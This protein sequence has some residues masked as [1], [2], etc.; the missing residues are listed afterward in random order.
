MQSS[1]VEDALKILTP[2]Q[3]KLSSVEAQRVMAVTDE[4]LSKLEKALSL[5]YLSQSMDRYSVSLGAD[6]V[7]LMTEYTQLCEEYLRLY[8]VL[9][10]SGV[11]PELFRVDSAIGS[12][13]AL[14]QSSM[15]SGSVRLEPLERREDPTEA[16]F[17][18]VQG[19]LRHTCKSLLRS[20]TGSPSAEVVLREAEAERRPRVRQLVEAMKDLRAIMHEKLLTTKAEDVKRRD[21]LR[22]VVEQQKIAE[23]KIAQLE[24]ELAE[25]QRQKNEEVCTAIVIIVSQYDVSSS[26]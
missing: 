2:A 10:A 12:Q 20:L 16:Q 17:C 5:S 22:S 19:Q 15:R 14:S 6:V 24:A 3:K 9:E 23:A 13:R 11:Q 1:T 7:S 21:H 26:V 18:V 8:E 25:A 4:A